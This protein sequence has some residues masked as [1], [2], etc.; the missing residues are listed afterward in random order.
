MTLWAVELQA[1]LSMEFPRQEYWSEL[2]FPFPRDLPHLGLRA[3]LH[4]QADSFPLSHQG[5]PRKLGAQGGRVPWLRIMP[6]AELTWC[7]APRLIVGGEDPKVAATDKFLIVHRE[8]RAR[9]RQELRV[10]NHLAAK[11][12]G[13]T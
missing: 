4:W 9:R 6:D 12:K 13:S 2:P 8:Q 7:I 3:P 1:P 10:K 5:S 11:N